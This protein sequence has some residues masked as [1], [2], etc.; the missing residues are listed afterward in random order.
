V[1]VV[2]AA[3]AQRAYRVRPSRPR[4]ENLWARY[5]TISYHTIPC[6]TI[7]YY[8]MLCY[9]MLCYTTLVPRPEKH[10]RAA[11]SLP[12]V[13]SS[14]PSAEHP[15]MADGRAPL[16]GGGAG[17]ESY[18]NWASLVSPQCQDTEEDTFACYLLHTLSAVVERA[19]EQGVE[20]GVELR[21]GTWNA[22]PRR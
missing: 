12:M 20:Q 13:A 22:T 14:L 16:S 7:P 18:E 19:A 4:P 5:Y 15:Q 2:R 9:A 3:C 1:D 8:T 11:A 6:H 17:G 10:G 21:N